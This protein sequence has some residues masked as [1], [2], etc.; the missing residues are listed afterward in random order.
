M[1]D[2]AARFAGSS[3]YISKV[4]KTSGGPSVMSKYHGLVRRSREIR[5]V[6]AARS[7]ISDHPEKLEP[8]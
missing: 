4:L 5:P 8:E 7:P 1:N 6:G 3:Y 2:P